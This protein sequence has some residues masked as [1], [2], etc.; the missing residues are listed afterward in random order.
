MTNTL[1]VYFTRIAFGKNKIE[2]W[3]K[4]GITINKN[5]RKFIYLINN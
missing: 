3:F 5:I 4:G 2:L 1:T